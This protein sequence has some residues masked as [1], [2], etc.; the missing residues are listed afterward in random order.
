[1]GGRMDAARGGRMDAARGGRM[2]AARGGRMDAAPSF[3]EEVVEED[4]S[5]AVTNS[6]VPAGTAPVGEREI[7]AAPKG[8]NPSAAELPPPRE[9][10]NKNAAAGRIVA[11]YAD[12]LGRPVLD[13][14]SAAMERDA[15]ALLAKGMSEAWLCDKVREMPSRGWFNLAKHVSYQPIEVVDSARKP[16][17]PEWCTECGPE[18]PHA[19][20]NPRFRTLGEMGSGEKCPRCHPDR[21][22]ATTT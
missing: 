12:A 10:S 4:L 13:D 3:S 17:L 18:T 2:D 7:D 14:V 16:G 1:R 8:H 6:A 15:A 5:L 11:A 22:G 19:R 21:V 20:L 9:G